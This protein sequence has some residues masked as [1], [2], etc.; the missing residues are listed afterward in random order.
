MKL[1]FMRFL[2]K[3]DFKIVLRNE[4]VEIIGF[5]FSLFRLIFG[6]FII[7]VILSKLNYI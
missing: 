2:L 1:I 7:S 5:G 6:F 4:A 3:K